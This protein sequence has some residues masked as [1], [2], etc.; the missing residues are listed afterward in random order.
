M[1]P[2]CEKNITLYDLKEMNKFYESEVAERVVGAIPAITTE[3]TAIG[4]QWA[5][6]LQSMIQEAT[7]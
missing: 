2:V 3:M 6:N 4:P 5:I 1:P 7:K